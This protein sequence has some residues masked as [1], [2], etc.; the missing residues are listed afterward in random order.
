MHDYFRRRYV[1][2]NILVGVAG[3]FDWPAFVELVEKHCGELG[4]PG[5]IGRDCVRETLGSGKLRGDDAARR[6]RS[7]TWC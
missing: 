3:N 1:A 2:P 7:N 6:W 5:P 4:T